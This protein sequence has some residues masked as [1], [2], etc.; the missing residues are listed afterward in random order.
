MNKPKYFRQES[1][2]F[3]SEPYTI[4][5]LS[6]H[7]LAFTIWTC[8]Q[9]SSSS[10]CHPGKETC[11][12]AFNICVKLWTKRREKSTQISWEEYSRPNTMLECILTL[13]LRVTSVSISTNLLQKANHEK[14][15]PKTKILLPSKIGHRPMINQRPPKMTPDPPQNRSIFSSLSLLSFLRRQKIS[16]TISFGTTQNMAASGLGNCALWRKLSARARDRESPFV[17]GALSEMSGDEERP[18]K[19][20]PF[21]EE[22]FWCPDLRPN[23]ILQMYFERE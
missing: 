5:L 11:K 17:G 18:R 21:C 22:A 2:I 4:F 20:P 15:A 12:H 19:D 9:F 7:S 23:L 14:A 16:R 8:G 3:F 1:L 6:M 13:F 10:R